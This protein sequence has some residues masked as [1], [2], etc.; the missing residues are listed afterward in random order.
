ML[1]GRKG[2]DFFRKRGVA[3]TGEHLGLAQG[4]A[5]T[6]PLAIARRS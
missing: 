2:R 5:T 1:I 6:T 3:I 4:A